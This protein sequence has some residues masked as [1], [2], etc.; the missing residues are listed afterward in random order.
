MKAVVVYESL[1]GNTAAI[2]GAIAEGLGEGA[3]ALPTSAA[4]GEALAGADLIVAGAPLIGFSLPTDEMRASAAT[5]PGAPKANVSD[6]SMRAWVAS[7]PAGGGRYAAFETRIWWSPG[8]AAKSIA[9]ALEAKG[10]TSAAP[11][12]KFM[13]T[14]KYGPLKAGELQRARAWGAKLARTSA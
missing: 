10:Y 7:L 11:G 12:E 6:P 9:T 13:V 14:G 4:K 5:T 2:A 3:T 1:W 8:S